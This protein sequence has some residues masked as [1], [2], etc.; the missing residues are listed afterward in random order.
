MRYWYLLLLLVVFILVVICYLIWIYF[1]I[2]KNLTW[3]I[4]FLNPSVKK[5]NIN[6]EAHQTSERHPNLWGANWI[7]DV[8]FLQFLFCFIFRILQ[9]FLDGCCASWLIKLIPLLIQ[10]H[11]YDS[12]CLLGYGQQKKD[13]HCSWVCWWRRAL[14]QN[15]K[16]IN[17]LSIF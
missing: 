6:D 8:I 12:A 15:C 3:M 13:L 10:F 9:L 14:W 5:R 1:F 4:F 7:R 2:I 16:E 11:I 17:R